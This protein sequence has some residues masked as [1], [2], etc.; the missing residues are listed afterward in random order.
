MFGFVAFTRFQEDCF[1]EAEEFGVV[2]IVVGLSGDIE[3]GRK[4]CTLS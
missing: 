1:Y 3:M 2:T 4:R